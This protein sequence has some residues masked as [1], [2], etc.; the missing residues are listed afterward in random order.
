MRKVIKLR[1]ARRHTS[2]LE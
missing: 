1:V 2:T